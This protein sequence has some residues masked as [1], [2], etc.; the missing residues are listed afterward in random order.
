M[1]LL[2]RITYLPV[3]ESTNTEVKRAIE[4][5][6]AEGLAVQ[7]G[8]QTGGY[9]RRGHTWESPEGGLYLSLLLRPDVDDAA[10]ST[11]PLVVGLA[12]R[13]ACETAAPA[14]RFA[15]K[16]P[17]DVMLVGVAADGAAGDGAAANAA[18]DAADPTVANPAPG[19][20]KIAG[21]SCEKHA[22]A[23]CLGIGV[24][25]ADLPG[26]PSPDALREALLTAFASRYDA[27]LAHG[28]APFAPELNRANALM[29]REVRIEVAGRVTASGTADSVDEVGRLVLR[30]T[31]GSLLRV[32][33][34][35]AHILL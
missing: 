21:I 26:A 8:R 15:V 24:D 34:G 9:G 1:A 6:E 30:G 27:W 28:F 20:Q 22:G 17:N 31:D 18:V 23:V 19:L 2:F 3:A 10:L 16:W 7:A 29:G 14:G 11:L 5:G 32:S 13:E 4:A 33:S 25:A 12:V 35:E